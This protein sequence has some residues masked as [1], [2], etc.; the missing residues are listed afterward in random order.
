MAKKKTDT[1]NETPAANAE[2][3]KAKPAAKK[4]SCSR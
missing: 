1:G 2:V 4:N 3:K